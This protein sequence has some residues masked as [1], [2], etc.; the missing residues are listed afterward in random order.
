[1]ILSC[2]SDWWLHVHLELH[3]GTEILARVTLT[4]QG[5]AGGEGFCP[6]VCL[7]EREKPPIAGGISAENRQGKLL[8]VGRT[9][10]D[11]LERT[12]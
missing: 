3:R 6:G 12:P 8:Y 1:M 11:G 10:N 4:G 7:A 9:L 5:E 2:E